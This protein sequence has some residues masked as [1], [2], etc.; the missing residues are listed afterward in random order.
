MTICH[1]QKHHRLIITQHFGSQ[2]CVNGEGLKSKLI[3]GIT[4]MNSYGSSSRVATGKQGH[5]G[6]NYR[7]P[8]DRKDPNSTPPPLKQ[9]DCLVELD[10]PEYATPQQEGR[11]HA[12]FRGGRQA[13]QDSTKVIR[14]VYCCHLKIPGRSKGGPVGVVAKTTAQ[15]IPACHCLMQQLTIENPIQARIHRNVK[16]AGVPIV[17]GYL[18]KVVGKL[19]CLFESDNMCIGVCVIDSAESLQILNTCLHNFR[20]QQDRST[21]SAPLEI[22]ACPTQRAVFAIGTTEQIQ[23]LLEDIRQLVYN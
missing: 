13:V 12:T 4:S 11:V 10:L 2:Q 9:C 18:N 7:P 19:G 17:E 8:P 16:Q 3:A 5:G 14:S 21:T 22:L 15:A 1:H 23:L 20:F 6:R